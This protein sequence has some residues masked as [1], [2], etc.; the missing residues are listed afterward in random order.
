MSSQTFYG[1][2]ATVGLVAGMFILTYFI[3]KPIQLKEPHKTHAYHGKHPNH[4]TLLKEHS[5]FGS[6][7]VPE[8]PR[9]NNSGTVIGGR[10]SKRYS[11]EQRN[12][13][14][15]RRK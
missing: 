4:H 3:K 1:I 7:N 13:R 5:S 14:T 12:K 11:K 10:K 8:E 2:Y 6:I 15:K 9:R